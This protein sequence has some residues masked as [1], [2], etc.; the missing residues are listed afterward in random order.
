MQML[1]ICILLQNKLHFERY[2]LLI[3]PHLI[4]QVLVPRYEN[5][6]TSYTRYLNPPMKYQPW[7]RGPQMHLRSLVELKGN[8]YPP[9]QYSNSRPNRYAIHNVLLAEAKKEFKK[10][11]Q[12]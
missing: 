11:G 9:L 1:K 2:Y 5:Y 8:P 4:I 12:L 3:I 10:T 7:H 6:T